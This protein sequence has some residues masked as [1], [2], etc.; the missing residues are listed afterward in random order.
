MKVSNIIK[1]YTDRLRREAKL[2][3]LDTLERLDLYKVDTISFQYSSSSG[4]SPNTFF[5]T[6]SAYSH[7]STFLNKKKKKKFLN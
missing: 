7:L 6:P 2:N 4:L 3:F 5:I 1:N